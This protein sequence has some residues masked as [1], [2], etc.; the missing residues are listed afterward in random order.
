[1]ARDK[2]TGQASHPVRQPNWKEV[3]RNGCSKRKSYISKQMA[4][5]NVRALLAFQW[6]G[7]GKHAHITIQ[8]LQPY[9]IPPGLENLRQEDGKSE[10]ITDYRVRP[11]LQKQKG[12]A[13]EMTP[14]LQSLAVFPEDAALFVTT[15]MVFHNPCVLLVLGDLTP[16]SSLHKHQVYTWCRNTFRLNAHTHKK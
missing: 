16:S 11:Y 3:H 14:C 7:G 2:A 5:C 9:C 15:Y 8:N 1:M 10:A 4:V 6:W 12:K 13:G